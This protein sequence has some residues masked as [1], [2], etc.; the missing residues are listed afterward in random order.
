MKRRVSRVNMR[1]YQ[2][3]KAAPAIRAAIRRHEQSCWG[4]YLELVTL[5]FRSNLPTSPT[6]N[7]FPELRAA[8]DSLIR[9]AVRRDALACLR[10]LDARGCSFVHVTQPMRGTLLHEAARSGSLRTLCWLIDA[11]ALPV[12]A[13]AARNVTPLHLASKHGHVEI[14]RALLARQSFVDTP[15]TYGETP[16]HVALF[17]GHHEIARVLIDAAAN[18][19]ATAMPGE[20]P[21]T[22]A[23]RDALRTDRWTTVELL[24]DRGAALGH[25]LPMLQDPRA[26]QISAHPRVQAARLESCDQDKVGQ[27]FQTATA[28]QAR[29]LLE[30]GAHPETA[31][32]Y[33]L[34]NEDHAL[35]G[36]IRAWRPFQY[37]SAHYH[38][39]LGSIQGLKQL[40]DHGG[41]PNAIIEGRNFDERLPL[42]YCAAQLRITRDTIPLLLR[43]G[44][45]PA[46]PSEL[47]TE[48][49]LVNLA[50][51][52]YLTPEMTAAYVECGHD[53]SVRAGNGK[54]ALHFLVVKFWD[55]ALASN[56]DALLRAGADVNA[57]D[58]YGRTPLM[59][60]LRAYEGDEVS[61][62]TALL[63][64]GAC[65]TAIDRKGRTVL[66]HLCEKHANVDPEVDYQ[67]ALHLLLGRGADIDA[68]CNEGY[69][70][71]EVGNNENLT[72]LRES[73]RRL[74]A[75]VHL[76]N[77]AAP[78]RQP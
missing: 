15:D 68:K 18:L 30:R 78:E 67:S 20:T 54:T 55:E 52:Y 60:F 53:V 46:A 74:R 41:D 69:Y 9:Y 56:L 76:S 37:T 50:R 62:I 64:A 47:T 44:A 43:Y 25:A 14:V 3:I 45:R 8:V 6:L 19:G 26:S 17:A 71:D 21:L 35:L 4:E 39:A 40:L 75:R 73:L 27:R 32:I 77:M 7:G 63:E 33:A 38:A 65:V 1:V 29:A 51:E 48:P 24:L 11:Q 2:L 59:D 42:I 61:G 12:G 10:V 72:D 66:H 57:T 16:L 22:T 5:R 70:A 36:L 28:E 13:H 23:T 31:A 34:R 49:L 58:R